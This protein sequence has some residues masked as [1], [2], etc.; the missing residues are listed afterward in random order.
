M[1][2]FSEQLE[3]GGVIIS[4]CPITHNEVSSQSRMVMHNQF[5]SAAHPG[6]KRQVEVLYHDATSLMVKHH[7]KA[8]HRHA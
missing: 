5:T 4:Q 8:E 2:F 3:A 6:Y 7:P 1:L